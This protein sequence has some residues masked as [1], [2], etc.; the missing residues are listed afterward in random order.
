[1]TLYP[2][3]TGATRNRQVIVPTQ[4][5]INHAATMGWCSPIKVARF[6]IS[7]KSKDP[8][9]LAWVLSFCEHASEHLAALCMFLYGTAARIS[10]A[11]RLK[12]SEV[13]LSA[14]TA[15]LSGD[16]PKPWTRIAHLPPA[17]IGSL[18]NIPSYRNPDERVFQYAGRGSVTKVWASAVKRAGVA[19]LTPHSCRHGFATM[20]M[21]EGFDLFTISKAGG[22]KDPATVLKYYGHALDDKTVTNVLF[23]T[24]VTQAASKET[25]T[26]SKRRI[27]SQ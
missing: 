5:I 6:D 19:P 3:A 11:T 24:P 8:A 27:K 18:A 10:E 21:R 16:K 2:T 20:M 17:V 25:V 7:P 1:M 13:D 15:H 4:A 22:W 9:A 26:N 14:G 12:W 23:D